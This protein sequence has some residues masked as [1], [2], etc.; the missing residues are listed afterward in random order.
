MLGR[1]AV[2]HHT[3]ITKAQATARAKE[4]L[5]E[6][7]AALTVTPRLGEPDPPPNQCL[8]DVPDAAKKIN[9]GGTSW[10]YDIPPAKFGA[11]AG[12]IL[13]HWKKQGYSIQ[14][15]RGFD[16]GRPEITASTRDGFLVSLDWSAKN[17]LSIGASSPCIYPDG[18][19]T[20]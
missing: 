11:V 8:D 16:S 2:T 13:D 19:A 14:A 1:R 10:L 9:V 12:Q 18:Q 20:S 5:R 6:T 4:I 17:L 7:A 15:A 3:T